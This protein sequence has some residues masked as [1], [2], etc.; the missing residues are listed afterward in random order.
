MILRNVINK[1]NLLFKTG[2]VSALAITA[3]VLAYCLNF[4]I[5][6]TEQAIL[7]SLI[8]AQAAIFAIVFSIVILGVRLAASRYS[9]RVVSS[10]TSDFS[11]KST[12]GIFAASIGFDLLILYIFNSIPNF[13]RTV[14]IIVAGGAAAVSFWMLYDFVN[15][16]IEKTTP[17]GILSFINQRLTPSSIV[18]SAHRAAEE[19]LEEDPFRDLLSVI[20]ATISDRDQTSVARGL[21]ILGDRLSELLRTVTDDEFE[22]G[23]PVDES[24]EQVCTRELPN[25]IQET[26]EEDLTQNALNVVD[27]AEKTGET[28][29]EEGLERPL[30]LV[31]RGQTDL[32][33]NLGFESDDERIRREVID[34][35]RGLVSDA[36]DKELWYSAAIGTRLLGWISAASIMNRDAEE[37]KDERYTTLLINGFPKLLKAT[38]QADVS[39]TNYDTTAWI[40]RKTEDV[41]PA[42]L[43][44]WGC[45]DS[46]AE[47]TSAAV[48]YEVRTEQRFLNWEHVAYGWSEGFRNL[49]ETDMESLTRTWLGAVLYLKYVEEVTEDSVMNGF[50]PNITY[51][52]D[53]GFA[54]ETIELMLA[55]DLDPTSRINFIPGGANPLEL[56]RTGTQVPIARGADLSFNEWLEHQRDV[57]DRIDDSRGGWGFSPDDLNDSDYDDDEDYIS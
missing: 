1:R 34:T 8:R 27:V 14:A 57:Y 49:Y 11:Y 55:G 50:D 28:A 17:K 46:M 51:Q 41:H 45:Y 32:I 18:A 47:L 13:A 7:N 42:D 33:D 30:E 36:V 19:S 24:L 21:K 3:S 39:L 6:G 15:D 16:T 12:V 23:S 53:A 37:N 20:Y 22:E 38:V 9:P 4:T 29:I 2:T 52:A 35:S 48:R 31:V 25:I 44:I 54:V 26:V 43:L 56:P 10:F 5:Q 40:R